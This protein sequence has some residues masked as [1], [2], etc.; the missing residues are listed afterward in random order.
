M[1]EETLT[2]DE[3]PQDELGFINYGN[4][5]DERKSKIKKI[6]EKYRDIF[7]MKTSKGNPDIPIR[8]KIRLID[9][10]MAGIRVTYGRRNSEEILKQEKYVKEL[11]ERGLIEKGTGEYS[12]PMLMVKKKDGSKRIVIDYRKL[13]TNTLL[14]D[15][16]IPRIDDTLDRLEGKALFT[17]LDATDGFWQI[18][19]EELSKDYTGFTVQGMHYRWRVMPM[20]LKGSSLTFQRAMHHILAELVGKICLVYIDDVI[21][22]GKDEEEHV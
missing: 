22:F 15:Y 7:K 3:E 20:G 17:T 1:E 13:N 21:M 18:L 4:M 12:A 14:D 5:S 11:L 2:V 10:K 19:M 16:S 6:L 8:H 9:D